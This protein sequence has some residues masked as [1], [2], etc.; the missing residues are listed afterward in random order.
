MRKAP[1]ANRVQRRNPATFDQIRTPMSGLRRA[2][3]IATAA[4]VRS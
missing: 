4:E 1:P 3:V 2:L